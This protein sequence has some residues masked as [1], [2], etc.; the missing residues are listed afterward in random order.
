MKKVLLNLTNQILPIMLGVYLGFAM[1]N[2][3]ENRKTKRQVSIFR[4]MLQ[5]EIQENLAEIKQVS[6]YHV[7]L[8]KDFSNILE[9]ENIQETFERYS[10]QGI[11]PGIVNNSAFNTGVQT[12][13]IQEFDL[14][15]IQDLNRLY[16]FQAK[17]NSFNETTIG[18]FVAKKF[19][20]TEPEIKSTLVSMVMNMNDIQSFENTLIDFYEK[21]LAAL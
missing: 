15:L 9:S 19:P 10:F 7:K 21:V 17:Y 14:Q 12:G 20:E 1:N 11:K 6:P 5:N 2:F 8:S 3:G 4:Q 18:S 13:I 16:T